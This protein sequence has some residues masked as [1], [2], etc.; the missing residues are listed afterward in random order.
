MSD[1]TCK[2]HI[3]N[4]KTWCHYQHRPHRLTLIVCN[5]HTRTIY[6]TFQ[7]NTQ[8]GKEMLS[9]GGAFPQIQY[10]QPTKKMLKAGTTLRP[11]SAQWSWS[12]R[13]EDRLHRL[14]ILCESIWLGWSNTST[15]KSNGLKLLANG[16]LD[17]MQNMIMIHKSQVY[18]LID[19]LYGIRLHT[20]ISSRL[21][22]FSILPARLRT[23]Y[24]DVLLVK[25]RSL[26]LLLVNK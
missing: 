2:L 5:I 4:K 10:S 9:H 22:S 11:D 3:K 19:A 6:D 24:H 14:C 23:Y 16:S 21:N 20:W 25:W 26:L 7:Q 8:V 1:S 18:R 17:A 15:W 12:C 13:L